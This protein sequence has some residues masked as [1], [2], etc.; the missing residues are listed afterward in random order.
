MGILNGVEMTFA[1]IGHS[2]FRFIQIVLA[3]AVCGLYGVD[4]NRAHKEHKYSDGKWVRSPFYTLL[5]SSLTRAQVFAEVVA[6]LSAVTALIYIIP[7]AKRIPFAFVWDT[8]LLLLWFALFGLFGSL[9]LKENP[10][11]DSGIIR[12]KHA[13]WVDLT[14]AFLWLISAAGMAMYWVKH[15][16]HR[17]MWTGRAKV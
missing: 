16:E 5:K 8:I 13:I 12:M 10:E 6:S 4:L 2:I 17:S 7:F 15:R 1:Y 9:Y 14:N 3:L 11:G